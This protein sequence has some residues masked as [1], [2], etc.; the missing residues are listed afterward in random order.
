MVQPFL[1]SIILASGML[2]GYSLRD[3]SEI[4]LVTTHDGEKELRPT[5]IDNVMR[6]IES[7]YLFDPDYNEMS[8]N[9]LYSISQGLDPFSA[10]I[11]PS[12]F[13]DAQEN[14]NAT[15]IGMGIYTQNY[16]D[17]MLIVEII[18]N[19]PAEKAGLKT[20][21]KLLKINDK[22]LAGLNNE[23]ISKEFRSYKG[24]EMELVITNRDYKQRI[25]NL[26]ID[27]VE[28]PT[29]NREFYFGNST[30]YVGLTQFSN[31]TYRELLS[32]IE[33]YAKDKKLKNLIIDVRD[34]PGGYLQEVV[35]ILDQLFN[36]SGLLLVETVYKDARKDVI[37]TSGRNFYEIEN[38]KILINEFSA[39]GSEVLAGA[40]QD[41]DR[42]VIIGNQS[43]GK[44]LV[45]D[46]Y[47]L[48]N[49]GAL[50]LT[51]ANY[52]L[53][54]GRS[55]QKRINL[56]ASIKSDLLYT[57]QDTFHSMVLNR[58][59][60]SGR[61]IDPDIIISDSIYLKYRNLLETDKLN[62]FEMLTDFIFRNPY[63][64][65]IKENELKTAD[66][67]ANDTVIN[68]F[69]KNQN[70]SEERVLVEILRSRIAYLLF[71]RKLETEILLKNDPYVREA[72]KD[73]TLKSLLN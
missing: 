59:L 70:P 67:F 28:T 34:N 43:F 4:S 36:T 62:V 37:K 13:T 38:V 53:P 18:N 48:F 64:L 71:G 52:Y 50:R 1:L 41:H 31:H 46:Q 51:V 57:D 65:N 7:N 23:Q 63:I 44:G 42:A 25:V 11:S 55:I 49:G 35:K 14:L 29:V 12:Q 10:Y 26:K 8:N 45:Q 72:L 17:T 60:L 30:L 58:P 66:L 32:I 69:L 33:K 16:K 3:S 15:Y 54:S 20:L 47:D 39:S 24:K 9:A 2:I 22:N 19:S 56:P 6:L 27:T 21:E 68:E 5:H 73:Q 61:G 40:L